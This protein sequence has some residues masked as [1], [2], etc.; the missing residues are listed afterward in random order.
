MPGSTLRNVELFASGLYRD[1]P[2]RPVDVARM[3]VNG[4]RLNIDP[5]AVVGHEE[6]DADGNPTAAPERTDVPADGW[7]DPASLTTAWKPDPVTG[8]RRLYLLGDITD[9]PPA[10]AAMIRSRRLRKVSAEVYDDFV[11]DAGRAHGK[12]LRRVAFLGGE[13][14]QV[15]GLADL[16]TTFAERQVRGTLTPAG[17]RATARGTFVAFAEVGTRGRDD[18]LKA[19]QQAMPGLNPA[20]ASAM[21][22]DQVA[23]LAKN[24][25][26]PGAQPAMTRDDMIAALVAAGEDQAA[27]TALSDEELKQLYDA[28]MGG[29]PAAPGGVET[30]ADPADMSREDLVA[31]LT[32]MGEDPAA[33]DAMS[34]DDLKAL[35][36]QLA[37]GGDVPPQPAPAAPMGEGCKK[38]KSFSE[39]ADA[40]ARKRLLAERRLLHAANRDRVTQFCETAVKA[41]QILPAQVPFFK[42]V[43]GQLNGLTYRTFSDGK[44]KAVTATA[45]DRAMALGRTLPNVIRFAERITQP[46]A[47]DGEREVNAVTRFSEVNAPALKAGGTTPAAYVETFKKLREK[48]PTLTAKEYGVPAEYCN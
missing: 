2:Y 25:P 5:P 34:D 18:N 23:D 31:E 47:A 46:A 17:G 26:T 36:A 16:P 4:R 13:P 28:A 32:A 45:L 20:T 24:L 48:R 9:V 11:D 15:K 35:Y 43:L 1:K 37:G 30:M 6:E 21:A 29:E 42:F 3:A 22:D 8:E 39:Q 27:L 10:V 44:G 41:G 19:I 14:P 40:L 33:L 7:V 12:A 38:H